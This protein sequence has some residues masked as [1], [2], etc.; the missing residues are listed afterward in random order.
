MSSTWTITTVFTRNEP[1][2]NEEEA[3]FECF[4]YK[5][6]SC[7]FGVVV[8]VLTHGSCRVWWPVHTNRLRHRRRSWRSIQH[9]STNLAVK[10]SL[11]IPVKLRFKQNTYMTNEFNIQATLNTNNSVAIGLQYRLARTDHGGLASCTYTHTRTQHARTHTLLTGVML[12][13]YCSYTS[14]S[15]WSIWR[16]PHPAQFTSRTKKTMV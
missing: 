9:S 8:D 4:Y 5:S 2:K 6:M 3:Q 11:S 7:I 15:I 14:L 16:L 10:A 12:P 1:R 13:T